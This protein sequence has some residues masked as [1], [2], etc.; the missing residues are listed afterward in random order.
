MQFTTLQKQEIF[1]NGYTVVPGVVPQVMVQAAR[2]AINNEL[3][4]GMEPSQMSIFR[5][6][7]YCP[8]VKNTPVITDLLN[9]TPAFALAES[10]LGEGNFRPAGG[11]QIALRFPM[12]RDP[13]P[14]AGPHLDGMS[15]PSN[16]VA[17]GTIGNFSM[18]IGVLLSD[19]PE[20]NA[21][22]FTVWPGTHR[23]TAK[24]FE[25]HG[26]DA[27]LE[28]MPK[29]DLPQPVQITGQAG[30]VVFCHYQLGHGI[31]PNSSSNIRYAIFFRLKHKDHD[32]HHRE[33]L[34]DIWRDWPG[35]ADI[36]DTRQET[37]DTR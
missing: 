21:G 11:G 29:I 10:L 19:L 9:K 33:V 32:S 31:T 6:Q 22:N 5:S 16:G 17:P 13:A 25:E 35:M 18:L 27:F 8:Q 12:M 30:D 34:S 20:P 28:G 15:S 14:K 4:E 24:Y 37:R 36:R 7:S 23:A 3:G 1:E 2:R 26:A